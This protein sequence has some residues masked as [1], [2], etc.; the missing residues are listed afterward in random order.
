MNSALPIGVYAIG[1]LS[2]LF[3]GIA[4]RQLRSN[5]S[6]LLA[7]VGAKRIHLMTTVLLTGALATLLILAGF[8][9]FVFK[10]AREMRLAH[11]VMVLGLWMVL[12][13]TFFILAAV[14]R[15]GLRPDIPGLAAP[16]LAVVAVA[17]LT[18]LER[19][20][21]VFASSSI[22]MPLGM[23]VLLICTCLYFITQVRRNWR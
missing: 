13:L 19:F 18:P 20:L 16:L 14:T 11:A 12:S 2:L 7:L 21:T 23:G 17:Y 1:L 15:L 4:L 8:F 9:T 3:T 6:Q 10:D 22:W 5:L